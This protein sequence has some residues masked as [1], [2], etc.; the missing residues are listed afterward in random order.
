MIRTFQTF[1]VRFKSGGHGGHSKYEWI[2]NQYYKKKVI[3]LERVHSKNIMIL[4]Y[5]DF[6]NW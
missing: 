5:I 1:F 6:N 4:E 3:L 2:I